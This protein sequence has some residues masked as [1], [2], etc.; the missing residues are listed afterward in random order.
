MVDL[1]EADGD[2]LGFD[3]AERKHKFEEHTSMPFNL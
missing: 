3:R 1:S 2:K